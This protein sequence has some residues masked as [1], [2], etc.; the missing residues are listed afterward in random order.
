V[1]DQSTNSF[2]TQT[3]PLD[4]TPEIYHR[5]S[6]ASSVVKSQTETP[7]QRMPLQTLS[8]SSPSQFESPRKRG[9]L[10][11]LRRMTDSPP[12]TGVRSP[13]A[14]RQLDAHEELR[15]G[16]QAQRRREEK[17]R[18]RA[19]LGILFEDEAAES[20]DDDMFGLAIK[21]P[22]DDEEDGEDLDQN[23]PALVDDQKMDADTEAVDL[24]LDKYQ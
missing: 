13:N 20:D 24:V 22:L 10:R 14:S 17:K 3:R 23:L 19:E 11:R 8:L 7:S 18:K 5:M 4:G 6:P 15:R 12:Q 2:L 1:V 9:S 16:Q 21:R